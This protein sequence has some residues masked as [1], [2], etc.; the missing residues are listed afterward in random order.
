M[1]LLNHAE[2]R[3][4]NVAVVVA[5]AALV[6]SIAAFATPL[7][8]E[9][10]EKDAAVRAFLQSVIEPSSRAQLVAVNRTQEDS[11]ANTYAYVLANIWRAW[12]S[13]EGRGEAEP[14]KVEA[15]SDGKWSVCFPE[16]D[17]LP[18]CQ[19]FADFQFEP[20]TSSITRFSVDDVPV[21][22][23]VRYRSSEITT[24]D[25]LGPEVWLT[26]A[27]TDP[28]FEMETLIFWT[29]MGDG[30][31]RDRGSTYRLTSMQVQTEREE[32]LDDPIL[33]FPTD[34]ARYE[35]VL[36]GI[37][38]FEEVNLVY[39]CWTYMPEGTETCNW[40]NLSL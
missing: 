31:E 22:E 26:A 12:E 37:R 9:A 21:G 13:S 14:G 20:G 19:I 15:R 39:A 29:Q 6:V 27:L 2:P 18:D 3:R 17:L 4:S 33:R 34:I 35:A 32:W 11:A 40:L 28:D 36:G 25:D 10:T 8:R 24:I 7:I 1:T 38:T 16:I 30:E 5:V 23:L